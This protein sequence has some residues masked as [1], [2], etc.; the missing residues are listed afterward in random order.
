MEAHREKPR[1]YLGISQIGESCARKMWYRFRWVAQETFDALTLKRFEDG[2]R[3][4]DLL[5][6]RL[7][8]V[9][10][11]QLTTLQPN[12]QQ[13]EVIGANPH[14][15]GHLDGGVLGL[16]QAPAT[17]H[18]FEAK[19]VGEEQLQKLSKAI[20]LHGEKQALRAWNRV[21]WAQ[22]L[23][24]MWLTG[25]ERHYLVAS[26]PGGRG[27]P[28]TV[29]T[30]S[31]PIEAARFLIRAERVVESQEPLERI[32]GPTYYECRWCA[33]QEQCHGGEWSA[34]NCRTCLH[35]TPMQDGTWLCQRWGRHLST[36][37][38]RQGCPT[39]LYLP[40]LVPG[41]QVD[42][43]EDWV[44]YRLATGDEWTDAEVKSA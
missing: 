10:G 37:E 2:H 43:G 4:E 13:W 16:L 21:Y 33:F 31:D 12:G 24:Y 42:A 44:L 19:C 23:V 8:A 18:V 40:M 6:A 38:Q 25:M 3:T 39:H 36:E 41:E 20:E 14:I 9:P 5:A 1:P 26:A 22:A 11:I 27:R 34:R 30:E 35:S 32:G 17:W 29:R 15:K 28:V 7:R